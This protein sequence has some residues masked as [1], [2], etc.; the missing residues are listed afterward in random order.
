MQHAI[1]CQAPFL[2]FGVMSNCGECGFNWIAG[3]DALPV[4][5]RKVEEGH[6]FVAIFLQ[7][8]CILGV[9]G[10]VG[11]DEEIESLIGIVLGL[12]LPNIVQGR[13]GFRLRKLG[14]AIEH[15]HRFVHPAA[16]L[17]RLRLG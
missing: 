9:F 4:L 7:A 8:Q 12:G 10:F 13:F 1:A 16:L 15:I 14:Q 5:G 6:E 11:F 2:T 17:P 3:A